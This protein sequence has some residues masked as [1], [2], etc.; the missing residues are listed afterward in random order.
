MIAVYVLAGIGALCVVCTGTLAA[1]IAVEALR[2]RRERREYIDEQM[3][4]ELA[5]WFAEGEA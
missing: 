2:Q 5:A 1:L 3:E 4:R